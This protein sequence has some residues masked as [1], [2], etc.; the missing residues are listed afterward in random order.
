MDGWKSGW[1][2]VAES[3]A[4]RAAFTPI[5]LQPAERVLGFWKPASQNNR[6]NADS[7]DGELAQF[8]IQ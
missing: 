4:K 6:P 5:R 3:P 2:P 8:R 1:L 7:M